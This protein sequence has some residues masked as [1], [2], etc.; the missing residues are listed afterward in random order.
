LAYQIGAFFAIMTKSSTDFD[1][2]NFP[3]GSEFIFG[4]WACKTDK[5]GNLQGWLV[6][7]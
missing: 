3:L 2:M 6:E 1:N 7:T 5:K 4:S